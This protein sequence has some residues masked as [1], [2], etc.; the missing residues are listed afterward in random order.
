MNMSKEIKRD[1]IPKLQTRYQ[2]RGRDGK[3]RML[4]ELCEDY[5]YDRKYAIKLLGNKLARPSP[6]ISSK[7]E[8]FKTG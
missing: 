3:S 2:N 8:I 6:D 4:D 7:P 5:G 1:L